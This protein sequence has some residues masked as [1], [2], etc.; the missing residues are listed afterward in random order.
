MQTFSDWYADLDD[1]AVEQVNAAVEMLQEH[2][3]ALRRPLV[4]A[5]ENSRHRNM[6][7]LRPGSLRV[8][9]AF[10]QSQQA[11]LLLAAD[12][13]EQGWNAWYGR[14]IPEA[15]RL[16]NEWLTGDREAN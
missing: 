7:E 2:D 1:G 15:D 13:A 6:K 4:G 5:I 12:K 3:P 10:D 9:F 16:F 14:A 11:I 8:L